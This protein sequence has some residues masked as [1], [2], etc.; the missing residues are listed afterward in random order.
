M[1][2]ASGPTMTFGSRKKKRSIW[3]D[4][5]AAEIIEIPL[6]QLHPNP[7]NPRL[8]YRDEDIDELTESIKAE[9][10][11]LQDLSVAEVGGFLEYWRER[12]AEKQPEKLDEL[13]GTLGAV[14]AEDY[15]ILIGHNRKLALQRAGRESA[16]CKIIN[17]KIPRARLLGLP[18]NMRRVPLNPVEQALAFQGALSDGLT[19]AEIA[20]QTG[21]RQPHI[22]RRLKLLKLPT[23]VQEAIMEGLAVSEAE[24]LLD[25]LT[26]PEQ[27][28]QAWKIMKAEGIKAAFAAARV[29]TAP[30]P[31]VPPSPTVP[32]Q[33]KQSPDETDATGEIHR[34]ALKSNAD[35]SREVSPRQSRGKEADTDQAQGESTPSAPDPAA[36]A[37]QRR[38]HACRTL[39]S[40]GVPSNPRETLR[41]LGP[42]LLVGPD[43]AARELA[44]AWLRSAPNAAEPVAKPARYFETV[45]SSGDTRLTTRVA[46]ALAL[47]TAELR[48]ADSARTW[49]DSDREYLNYLKTGVQ[50]EPTEWEQDRLASQ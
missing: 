11:L 17:S 35:G 39:V 27:Q 45:A 13:E 38:E 7:F 5:D 2:G 44:H 28:L 30:D 41:L 47:A 9:D 40:M 23:E 6:E 15:V 25:R 12:L 1:A 8:V 48:A 50:Y 4:P 49:D 37:A 19:Q 21:T 36:E 32:A 24:T 16:P 3:D 18:E 26:S 14:P 29:L 42:A 33:K 10:G 43:K 20:Q 31:G 34:E 22:S 46:F